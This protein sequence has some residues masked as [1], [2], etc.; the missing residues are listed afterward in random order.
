MK[1]TLPG[2]LIIITLMVVAGCAN[3]V[4]TTGPQTPAVAVASTPDSSVSP[5]ATPTLM[6]YLPPSPPVKVELSLPTAPLLNEAIELTCTVTSRRDAPNIS[7]QIKLP[8]GANLSKGNLEWWGDFKANEPATFS[9]QIVFIKTGHWRIEATTSGGGL[10]VLFLNIG[11]DHSEFG[12]PSGPVAVETVN[13]DAIPRV[14]LVL[15]RI[16]LLNEPAEI[17][18]TLSSSVE[19]QNLTLQLMLPPGAAVTT[20]DPEWKGDLKAGIPVTFSKPVI[21]KQPGRN[22]IGWHLTQSGRATSWANPEVICLNIGESWSSLCLEPIPVL[23][24]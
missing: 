2:I 20:V 4:I 11:T 23:P 21:F 3:P 16:P 13:P 24:K 1:I 12:W 14:D 10:G 15:A 22:G 6:Q 17:T 8:E 19:L 9:A 7:A 5:S 18:C